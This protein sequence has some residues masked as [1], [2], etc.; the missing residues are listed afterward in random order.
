MELRTTKYASGKSSIIYSIDIKNLLKNMLDSNIASIQDPMDVS[1]L[2]APCKTDTYKQDALT[3]LET[4]YNRA[5]KA[6]DLEQAGKI[7]EAFSMWDTFFN[8]KFPAYS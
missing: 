6:Y 5:V 1:G 2:I 3:K 7:Q 4:A 8:G